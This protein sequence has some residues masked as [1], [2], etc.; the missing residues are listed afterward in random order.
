MVFGIRQVGKT[1]I[2][3]EFCENEYKNYVYVNLFNDKRFIELYKNNI[4]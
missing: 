3:E 4:S 1:Y 2:T